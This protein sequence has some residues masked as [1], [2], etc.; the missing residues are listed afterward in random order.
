[1]AML[2]RRTFLKIAALGAALAAP[3]AGR[4]AAAPGRKP[5][6]IF[7]YTDDM[8]WGDPSCCGYKEVRT[9][10]LDRLAGEGVR[11][12]QFYTASPI[13]SPSRAGVTTGMFPARWR[14]NDYLHQRK[15]NHDHDQADWLDPKAPTL[16][17]ALKQAGYATAHF[18]KWH[19]G[20][21]RDVTDA[22]LPAAY[23]FDE[24]LVSSHPLE[25]M[26]PAL[27]PKMPRHE[28]TRAFVD[29]TIEFI[30]RHKDGPFFVN[31][32][33]MDVHT[34]HVPD[35]ELLPHYTQVP[36]LHRN[37]DAVLEEYDFHMGRLF[38]FLRDAG[39]EEGTIVVF[40]SDNGPE[41]SFE[42]ERS[43]GLR[44]MKWSLYE[45]GIRTPLIVRWKGRIP[46]GK[47]DS[48]TVIGGV[49]LFPSL[50][51][52]AGVPMPEGFNFDGEDLSGALLGTPARRTKPLFWEYGRKPDYLRPREEGDRSPNVAVRDGKWKLLVNADGSR[53]ELYDI[54]ADPKETADL[55]QKETATADALRVMALAWRRALP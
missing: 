42:H 46:A 22:P 44:G 7:I 14:I 32:W 51:A 49:D 52:L 36:P 12:L 9:K 30:K 6:I 24:S 5:N 40:S 23:G 17:R 54:E 3:R 15:A 26:G 20:G 28:T 2:T 48:S 13:C 43:A 39:L 11:F 45:G 18:G 16:A 19:M 41:P 34:P 35:P 31:L 55:A 21:G 50:C 33:P 25:G 27:D 53:M 47:V 8:G 37:F 10:G 38:D 29:R 4:A 1:M